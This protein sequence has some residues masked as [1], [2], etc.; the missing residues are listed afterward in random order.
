MTKCKAITGSAVKGGA[1]VAVLLKFLNCTRLE[2]FIHTI[3]IMVITMMMMIIIIIII[4]IIK[5]Y[6][7]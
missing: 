6:V 4:I 1:L 3:I 2:I 7:M 5:R